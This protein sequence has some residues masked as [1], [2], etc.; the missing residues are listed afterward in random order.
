MRQGYEKVKG[1]I[2][3]KELG[4]PTPQTI[5]VKDLELQ[6]NDVN[7]FL[8][9][10]ELVMV[11]S[12]KEGQPTHCPRNLK[13]KPI[14]AKEFIK[15]LNEDNYIAIL[16]DYVPL[17]NRYSGNILTLSDSF[18]VELVRGGPT[19]KLNRDGIMHEHLRLDSQGSIIQHNG[20]EVIPRNEL[21]MIL[22]RV[23]DLPKY[24]IYEFSSGP[25]WFY[26]WQV[27]DD[28]TSKLLDNK[29]SQ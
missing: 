5:F 12:D 26:F 1:I 4:L 17:N 13:C 2:K 8:M 7:N 25:D 9:N 18:I 27:R 22:K 15:K 28:P 11:R 29:K 19:S 23:K 24:H 16:Q 20:E 14:D 3:L 10:K 6:R 21:S